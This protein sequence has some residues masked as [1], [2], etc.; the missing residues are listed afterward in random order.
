MADFGLWV[1]GLKKM[2]LFCRLETEILLRA[3][4]LR[5]ILIGRSAIRIRVAGFPPKIRRARR[6]RVAGVA[7]GLWRFLIWRLSINRRLVL[8]WEELTTLLFPS[9]GDGGTDC[10]IQNTNR[11]LPQNTFI[12]KDFFQKSPRDEAG[13]LRWGRT[14]IVPKMRGFGRI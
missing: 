1:T 7:H 9:F 4:E 8:D 14:T 11:S 2:P 6:W 3:Q 12:C 13:R 10:V 5:R